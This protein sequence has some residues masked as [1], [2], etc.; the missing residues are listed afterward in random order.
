MYRRA[1]GF[2]APGMACL[3]GDR[4]TT[5]GEVAASGDT[6]ASITVASGRVSWGAFS[7][8]QGDIASIDIAIDALSTT[9]THPIAVSLSATLP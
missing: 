8:G 1:R 9:A 3:I 6:G 7:A 5:T 2:V 4:R